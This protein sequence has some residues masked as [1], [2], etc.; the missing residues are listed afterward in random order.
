MK[1]QPDEEREVDGEKLHLLNIN[2][3]GR[4]PEQIWQC[5]WCVNPTSPGYEI[6]YGATQ[7]DAINKMKKVMARYEI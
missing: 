3:D 7:D 1:R 2:W 4:R 5:N 6:T